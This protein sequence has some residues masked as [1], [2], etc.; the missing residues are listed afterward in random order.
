MAAPTSQS[1]LAPGNGDL[2]LGRPAGNAK[3]QKCLRPNRGGILVDTATA[4]RTWSGPSG[5]GV[6]KAG[7]IA[8]P[9]DQQMPDFPLI[10][11]WQLQIC[12]CQFS[13][14]ERLQLNQEPP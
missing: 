10:A 13:I 3:K 1:L 4:R 9:L 8:N 12:N 11:N 2:H 7:R 14:P 6:F 5:F